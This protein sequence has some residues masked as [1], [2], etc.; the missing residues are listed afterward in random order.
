MINITYSI[1]SFIPVIASALGAS[2]GQ[3][4]IGKQALESM[5]RQPSIAS[6]I[7]RLSI[8]AIAITETAAVMGIVIS[9]LLFRS[10][11]TITHTP[12]TNLACA[13]IGLAM[14]LS[15]FCAG[16][17]SSFPAMATCKSLS[18]QPF[19]QTKLLNL[20]LITQTLIMTPNMFGM[21]ITL[22]IKNKL[23]YVSSWNEGL[24]LFSSGLSIGL[25]CIG[26]SI[27]LSLFSYA[28]CSAVGINTNSFGKIMTF[29]FI[30][31]AIIETPVI[32]SLLISLVIITTTVQ[33]ESII[34]G[35]QFV[36]A[37]LCIGLSTIAPGIN[38]GKTAAAA[39]EQIA[40][41]LS[42]Y[43]SISKLAMLALAMIDSFTIYGLL[44]S[45]MILF[46]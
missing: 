14:G 45:I 38:S 8:V 19:F 12:W 37:A 44:I 1:Y 32:L 41:N 46:S 16:I 13:G 27:G 42:L 31:E 5:Y 10:N 26:P 24:Q 33:P 43:P 29:T 36:A 28:A 40:F 25:G 23:A 18:R 9:M 34:Q 35:W 17:T 6:S 3:G 30:C 21:I 39:C 22:L 11:D 7:A 20:M 4:M 15:G 2:I